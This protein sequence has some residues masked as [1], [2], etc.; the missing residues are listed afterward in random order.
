MKVSVMQVGPIGTN[1]YF[2]QDEESG[3]MAIIDP[4]DDWDRILH[5]V[6]KAE[7]EV[8]YILL[9]HGHY[10][11][12]T[13]VPDL[14]KALPG[15][16]VYIHQADANGAGSQL[17][18]LAAQVEDLNNYDEGDTL[19]LGSLTI[20]VLHTPG[21]SKGSVTLKVGDVLFTGDTLFCGSCGRTD[22]RGGSYEEI[23]ESLK[24]LGELEGDFHV[25]PGHDRTSTLERERKY[26]P[27][28]LEAMG[29]A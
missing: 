7:G 24:R 18:P 15:V 19:S 11:H 13:A 10:D 20:E 28:L 29:K 16:Q 22:L 3:L 26:N 17:F 21:H 12:T 8:K 9:T 5:Q 6:K 4:G 27:F 14:V 2:L 23:M 1:C 25:C